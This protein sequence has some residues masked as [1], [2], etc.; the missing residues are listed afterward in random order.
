[1]TARDRFNVPAS[2]DSFPA[3]QALDDRALYFRLFECSSALD[4]TALAS[5]SRDF[6]NAQLRAAR[7]LACDLPP[8]AK[9]LPEWMAQ[10]V[11][12]TGRQYRNYV[13]ERKS[14]APRRLFHSKSH[15]LHFIRAVAPTKMVDGAWL[16][17][18]LR[19]WQDARL[20]PLV[21]IYLEELGDGVPDKNHV[22]LYEQ[23]LASQ[24][25]ADWHAL[26]SRYYTQGA[27]QLALARHGSEF[28]PEVI[29][30]NLGYEQLPLHLPVTAFELQELGIDPYYFSLHVTIDNAASG[31][32]RKAVQAVL[33]MMPQLGDRNRFYQRVMDGYR[34]NMLGLG[35]CQVIDQFDLE[36]ALLGV[37]KS[38]A[39]I[40][41]LL[42]GDRCRIAG[43]TVAD[44]LSQPGQMPEL[45]RALER[46]GWVRRGQDPRNSRF[47]QLLE[48][49]RA[50]MFGVF[51]P[52]EMQLIW[53]WIAQ[54]WS[55]SVPSP[56]ARQHALRGAS[57]EAPT[58]LAT[59][60][61]ER[62]A[63]A[64]RLPRWTAS[65]AAGQDM[66]GELRM[67]EDRLGATRSKAEAMELLLPLLAPAA[68]HR[69]LGLMAT[70]IVS[71]L[72]AG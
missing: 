33:G 52:Y 40:G 38:K 3:E 62:R 70:R 23:L 9:D 2:Q 17:G 56:G 45:L 27:I 32:A 69:P 68:H 72:L 59:H 19:H 21:R 4:D 14:G 53:D 37:F 61:A 11:Q 63:R 43:K 57:V 24:G 35:S 36:Q 28:L 10:S 46:A 60:A 34:L 15:A 7:S 67:L 6:L 20:E 58:A 50:V 42:H 8:D 31:H 65:A 12:A 54:D 44:W 22:L 25:C 71:Q 51:T 13:L 49:D 5:A 30:F 29:G 47:W 55:E 18:L 39:A 41:A 66:H 48:G 26:P 64:R 16:Y 1:M